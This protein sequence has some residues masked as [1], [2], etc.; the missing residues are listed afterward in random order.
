MTG[1]PPEKPETLIF[2]QLS[3]NGGAKNFEKY[4]FSG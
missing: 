3:K 2:L 4:R 1:I